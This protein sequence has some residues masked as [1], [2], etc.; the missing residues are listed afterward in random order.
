MIVFAVVIFFACY[1]DSKK[2]DKIKLFDETFRDFQ[3]L[4]T[5]NK[6]KTS[7]NRNK[8]IDK[9]IF[10]AYANTMADI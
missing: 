7:N 8:D 10:K 4:S 1:L 5:D 6:N 9:E 3:N 2:T